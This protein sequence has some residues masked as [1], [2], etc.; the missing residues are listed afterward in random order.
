MSDYAPNY[1]WYSFRPLYGDQ[2]KLPRSKK[3]I[4]LEMNVLLSEKASIEEHL[5]DKKREISLKQKEIDEASNDTDTQE[6]FFEALFKQDCVSLGRILDVHR[7]YVD[8]F[9]THHFLDPD[10]GYHDRFNIPVLFIACE[11]EDRNV[12]RLILSYKPNINVAF[13]EDGDNALIRY[14]RKGVEI[15]NMLLEAGINI[16]YI[17]RRGH[18]ALYE[19][20]YSGNEAVVDCLLK[21]GAHAEL[22]ESYAIAAGLEHVFHQYHKDLMTTPYIKQIGQEEYRKQR[23]SI[24]ERRTKLGMLTFKQRDG[25]KEFEQLC[26]EKEMLKKAAEKLFRKR[27]IRRSWDFDDSLDMVFIKLLDHTI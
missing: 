26:L 24:V 18:T 1:H 15:V 13:D 16:D 25:N 8:F 2:P 3:F 23:I 21:N 10:D 9:W 4:Q 5:E 17:P 19:A 20:T 11:L 14:F 12:L 22:H 6:D 7:E 27:K